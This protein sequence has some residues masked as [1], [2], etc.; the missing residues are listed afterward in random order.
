MEL[1]DVAELEFS[2]PAEDDLP[3]HPLEPYVRPSTLRD[4]AL[5]PSLTLEEAYET[6]VLFVE[7]YLSFEKPPSVDFALFYHYM[8]SD[9]AAASD[10]TDAVRRMK[11]HEGTR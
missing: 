4:I 7:R 5:P 2:M 11:A 3:G 9:P 8:L 6:T 1:P 10:F